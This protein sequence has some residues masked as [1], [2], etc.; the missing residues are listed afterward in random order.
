MEG[1]EGYSIAVAATGLVDVVECSVIEMF[2]T[3]GKT[4]GMYMVGVDG[5]GGRGERWGR[6]WISGYV[7][8]EVWMLVG[9]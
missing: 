3:E 2:V 5:V 9:S 8:R 1:I 7:G 4:S 6:G